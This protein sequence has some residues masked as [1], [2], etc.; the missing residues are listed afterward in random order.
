MTD[1]LFFEEAAREVEEPRAWYRR[2]SK[3]AEAMFL[4]EIDHAMDVIAEA[5]ELAGLP[6]RNA[7]LRISD[8]PIL[9]NLLPRRRVHSRRRHRASRAPSRLLEEAHVVSGIVHPTRASSVTAPRPYLHV[10]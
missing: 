8:V 9:R 10:V 7:A 4:R 3:S 2:R 1:L 6:G 5:P